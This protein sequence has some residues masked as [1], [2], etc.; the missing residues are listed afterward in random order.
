MRAEYL[1]EQY[2]LNPDIPTVIFA[3]SHKPS[4]IDIIGESICEATAGMNL[5]VKLHPFSWGGKYAPHRHHRIFER[6]AR[7]HPHVKLVPE[8]ERDIVP[9]LIGSD[10]I[11]TGTSST[12]FEMLAAGKFGVL[13]KMANRIGRGGIPMLDIDPTELFKGA[14]PM[15][16]HREELRGAILKAL[17]PDS[18]MITNAARLRSELFF[19][20]NGRASERVVDICERLIEEGGHAYV[21]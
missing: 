16:Y 17:S 9:F 21:A 3:P 6:A 7:R 12:M 20:L 1:I 14:W 15:V 10:I 13:I 5:L 11:I 4:A 19:A 8:K 2:K 18:A